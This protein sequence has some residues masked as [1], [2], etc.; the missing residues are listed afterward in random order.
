ML[1]KMRKEEE[2]I[3]PIQ[4]RLTG[5]PQDTRGLRMYGGSQPFPIYLKVLGG[6]R[7]KQ[8][9]DALYKNNARLQM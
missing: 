1:G 8:G 7:E 4:T 2:N 3:E 6:S 9:M 5:P